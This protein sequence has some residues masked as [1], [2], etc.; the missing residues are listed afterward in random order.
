MTTGGVAQEDEAVRVR[1]DL[2][3]FRQTQFLPDVSDGPEDIVHMPR[4][5]CPFLCLHIQAEDDHQDEGEEQEGTGQDHPTLRKKYDDACRHENVDQKDRDKL[6]DD[7]GRSGVADRRGDN[8]PR[9][10]EV[11]GNVMHGRGLTRYPPSP[12][13]TDDDGTQGVDVGLFYGKDGRWQMAE[14]SIIPVITRDI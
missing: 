6:S 7:E 5:L 8:F 4:V 11:V 2:L 1:A 3:Q 10:S 9:S 13:D 12:V 14:R